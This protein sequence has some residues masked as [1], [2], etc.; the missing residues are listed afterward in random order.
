MTQAKIEPGRTD[1]SLAG[2]KKSRPEDPGAFEK[3][4]DLLPELGIKS[5]VQKKNDQP[6]ASPLDPGI[7][8]GE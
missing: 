2:K 5:P 7:D 6:K 1:I 8:L 3:E 4:K